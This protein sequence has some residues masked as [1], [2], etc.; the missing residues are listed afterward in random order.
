[1]ANY[2]LAKPNQQRVE[3]FKVTIKG[4][5]NDAD[6]ITT[7]EYYTKEKFETIVGKLNYLINEFGGNH[8]LEEFNEYVYEKEN[9]LKGCAELSLPCTEYGICH[10]LEEVKIEYVDKD[11][12]LWEVEIFE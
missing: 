7:E 11:G 10:T 3:R 2:K 5:S 6:Y 8:Q 4:D 9:N 12:K 1:M